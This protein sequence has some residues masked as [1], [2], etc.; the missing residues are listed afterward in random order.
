MDAEGRRVAD[1]NIQRPAI[2][3]AVQQQAG[4]E[5]IGAQESFA[6]CIL[7]CSGGFVA[8][9]A[10]KT[11]DQK[12]VVA[13]QLEVQVEAPL[14]MRL[15]LVWMFI[16]VVITRHIEHWDI[17]NSD[18]VF[19]I[20]VRQIPTAKDQLDILKLPAGGECINPIEGLIADC[21]NSHNSWILP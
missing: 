13:N 4:D 2:L 20:R 1:E 8:D 18:Q 3:D 12:P 7:I 14:G 15:R 11:A 21:Q 5:S 17:Q 10:A 6:L 9:G 16:R 19:E